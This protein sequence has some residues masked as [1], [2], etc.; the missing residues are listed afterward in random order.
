[1]KPFKKN[2]YIYFLIIIVI[3]ALIRIFYTVYSPEIVITA[4]S[5]GYYEHGQKMVSTKIF[6]HDSRP[7]VYPVLLNLATLLIEKFKTPI[8]SPDFYKAMNMVIL[9]QT[10]IGLISLIILFR[11]LLYFKIS[12]FLSFIFCLFIGCNIMLFAQEQ[13]ILTES[14]TTVLLM[15]LTFT[16]VKII[17]KPKIF[18]FLVLL[19]LLLLLLFLKPVYIALP[20]LI[21]PILLYYHRK[22]TLV[23]ISIFFIFLTVI[24]SV[25]NYIRLN[26]KYN[27]YPGFSRIGEIDLLGQ[28]L[29][30][31]LPI[32]NAKEVTYFY[33]NMKDYRKTGREL[34]PFRFLE[35]YDYDIYNKPL[36]LNQ[37]RNFDTKVILS[38][39]P[40]FTMKTLSQI[41]SALLS[42]NDLALYGIKAN[43]PLLKFI[44]YFLFKIYNYLQIITFICIPAYLVFLYQFLKKPQFKLGA[45]VILGTVSVFH[46][47]ISVVFV[48]HEFGRLLSVTQPELYLF[49]F[50]SLGYFLKFLNNKFIGISN[51]LH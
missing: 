8:L 4:D 45:I 46:I 7:P 49:S 41:P 28:I 9:F 48:T 47:I 26:A 20:F 3:P 22:N 43:F 6:A 51:P 36:L 31:R 21:L 23:L 40:L 39:L 17:Y 35:Y 16:T 14:L 37:L 44:F 19:I 13:A 29:Y 5:Y 1:M 32:E 50:I 2:H 27:N 10:I 11:L 12:G 34:M 30:F 33:N 25:F 24:I 18:F 42:G 15:V 38:N